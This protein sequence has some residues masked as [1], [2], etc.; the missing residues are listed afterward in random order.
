MCFKF[1]SLIYC[2]LIWKLFKVQ[3]WLCVLCY[4]RINKVSSILL[5]SVRWWIIIDG[6]SCFVSSSI[7]Y[8]ICWQ[9][10]GKKVFH[11]IYIITTHKQTLMSCITVPFL[12]SW[13][14]NTATLVLVEPEAEATECIKCG[15]ASYHLRQSTPDHIRT[16]HVPATNI[17]I[18]N[19]C[20]T[21]ILNIA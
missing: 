4:N 17:L 13:T 3:T 12:L 18:L 15:V 8:S 2:T 21:F 11:L 1:K 5:T 16:L 20:T 14:F 10:I 7:I 9:I 6:E 19:K